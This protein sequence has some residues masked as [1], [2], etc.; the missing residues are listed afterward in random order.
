MH[1]PGVG[2]L[3]PWQVTFFIVGLPG[4][5]VALLILLTVRDPQRKG[6]RHDAS[7]RVQKPTAGE[8]FRF[9][10]RHR[11]T[12]CCHYLGFS[13]HAMILFCLLGWT[14]AFYMRKFGMSPVEAGYMPVSY[15]HL[16]VYKRQA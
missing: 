7:G 14:P 5:L 1:V 3:R 4:V 11:G 9:L 16:D 10:G 8:V 15:T 13:F 2:E 12:F 6:L